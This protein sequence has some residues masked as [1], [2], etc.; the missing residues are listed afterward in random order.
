MANKPISEDNPF[1]NLSDV[2]CEHIQN[3]Y[4]KHISLTLTNL[5]KGSPNPVSE[6]VWLSGCSNQGP[7]TLLVS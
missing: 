3:W 1:A 2:Q 7:N 4:Q 5:L 6:R